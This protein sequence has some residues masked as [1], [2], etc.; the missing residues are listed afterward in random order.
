M[1][2]SKWLSGWHWYVQRATSRRRLD[3]WACH[4]MA[5]I[6]WSFVMA[7]SIYAAE[8]MLTVQW[9]EY[10]QNDTLAVA[11]RFK[12]FMNTIDS[13]AGMTTIEGSIPVDSTRWGFSIEINPGETRW[14]AMQSAADRDTLETLFGDLSPWTPWT[15]LV[16]TTKPPAPPEGLRITTTFELINP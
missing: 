8:K 16:P 3:R 7:S 9:N 10:V 1:K 5:L 13:P 14:F 12:L 4:G 15:F 11:T 6:I 2:S